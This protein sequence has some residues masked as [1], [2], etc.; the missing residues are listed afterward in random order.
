MKINMTRWIALIGLGLLFAN[1]SSTKWI[2]QEPDP[3]LTING[4]QTDW[5][6]LEYNEKYNLS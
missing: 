6:T 3:Q 1:C 2:S 4:D 5:H